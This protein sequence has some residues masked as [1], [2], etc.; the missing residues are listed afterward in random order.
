MGYA[1]QTFSF[2]DSWANY[3]GWSF[4]YGFFCARLKSFWDSYSYIA[5]TIRG[6]LGSLLTYFVYRYEGTYLRN[7]GIYTRSQQGLLD[8]TYSILISNA[9]LLTLEALAS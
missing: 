6:D 4:T 7:D 2:V 1:W 8:P 9:V 3:A 5:R